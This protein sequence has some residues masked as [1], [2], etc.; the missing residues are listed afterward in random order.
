MPEGQLMH[1]GSRHKTVSLTTAH[2]K[3]G[4]KSTAKSGRRRRTRWRKTLGAACAVLL[5]LAGCSTKGVSPSSPRRPNPSLALH[6]GDVIETA[7]G[8]VISM[9]QLAAKLSRVAVV[10]VGETHTSVEDHK[11]QLEIM[12][13]LSRDG[14]CVE[15]GMEMF[16]AE[17]QPVLDRYINGQMSER[18]FLRE[19]KWNQVWGFPYFL[20]KGLI[21]LQKQRH[22]P[23]IGLN[24]PHPVVSKIARHGLNSLTPAERSRVAAVFHLDNPA[25]RERIK[26]AFLAH[27]KYEIKDFESF[28]EAQLAWEETMA[29]TL[30]RRLAQTHCTIVVVLGKGH[31]NKLRGVPHLTL[32]RR[33]NTIS[34]AVV[35]VP[36]DTPSSAIDPNLA[37]YVVITGQSEPVHHPRLGVIIEPAAPAPGVR[38]AAIIL[39]S[40]A[41]KAHLHRGDIILSVNGSAVQDAKDVQRALADTGQ[42]CRILIERNKVRRTVKVTISP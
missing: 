16:P 4:L 25:D 13:R 5:V 14:R 23:V 12:K 11:V 1:Y 17:A 32:L 38:I 37:D 18:D 33:P 7:T 3:A 22:M 40:P 24:A 31:T 39:N 42:P 41:E 35:P 26:K 20:Y 2:H 8:R 15:L 19:V 30:A 27:G 21:D 10:Y 6:T 34:G 9:D 36:V 28:F 29:Q